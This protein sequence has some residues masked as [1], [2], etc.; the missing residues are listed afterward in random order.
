MRL[1]T[2]NV[3]RSN[4]QGADEGFP[5]II[6]AAEVVVEESEFKADFIRHMAG[7][8]DWGAMRA[9]AQQMGMEANALP[10][11]LTD[12]L[13]QDEDFLRAVHKVVMD[14]HLVE[15]FLVCPDTGRKFPVK[16]GVPDMIIEEGECSRERC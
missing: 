3:L 14:I 2:H 12:E 13:L 6:E 4:V 16:N 10:E 1:L 8:L 7:T 9:A 15:G 5:L 11:K